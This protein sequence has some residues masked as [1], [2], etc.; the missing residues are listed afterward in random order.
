MRTSRLHPQLSAAANFHGLIDYNRTAFAPP[1]CT[2]I[3]DENPPQRRAWDPFGQPCYS[4]GTA[5]HDY[6]FQNMYITPTA[7]ER[8][9][10][11]L[12]FSPHSSPMLQLSSTDRLLMTSNDM[13]YALK[14][15]HPNVPLNTVGDIKTMAQT[16]LSSIFKNKYNKPPAP[17]IIDSPLKA[18]ENERPAVLI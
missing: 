6:R 16:T 13:T 12:E 10:N 17:V 5:M 9:M 11:T 8:I 4:L 15:T 18:S 14:Y 3:A 1:G 2:L 7:S